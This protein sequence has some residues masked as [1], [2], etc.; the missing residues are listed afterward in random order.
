MIG[1]AT[2]VRDPLGAVIL[3]NTAE[4]DV[5][6]MERRVSRTATLDGESVVTDGGYS[7]GDRTFNLV[8]Q[9]ASQNDLDGVEYLIQNYSQVIVSTERG[10]FVGALES[11]KLDGRKLSLTVL[12]TEKIS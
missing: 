4:S 2:Q 5:A 9:G 11:L 12:V 3:A 8:C 6:Q 10:C 1:L 7:A